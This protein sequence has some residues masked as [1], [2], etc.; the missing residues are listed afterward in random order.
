MVDYLLSQMLWS[1]V[2]FMDNVR[3]YSFLMIDDMASSRCFMVPFYFLMWVLSI[4]IIE[5]IEVSF[6]WVLVNIFILGLMG[7]EEVLD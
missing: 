3:M 6:L 7:R 4:I 1:I 2:V 5:S